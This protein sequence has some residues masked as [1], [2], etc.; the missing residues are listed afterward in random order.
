MSTQHVSRRSVARGAAWSVPIVAIAVAAPAYAA[1]S[2]TATPTPAAGPS[3]KCPGSGGNNFNFKAAIAFTTPGSDDWK[4][5]VTSWTF[6]GDNMATLPA[7]TTLTGGEGNV[8]L[9]VNRSNSAAKHIV[10]V[11]YTATN[12]STMETFN[13]SFGPVELTFSPTCASPITCP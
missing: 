1:S 12:L 6:D 8:I 10:S 7:D 11:V 5:S 9:M 13:G 4:I 2:P 3:C